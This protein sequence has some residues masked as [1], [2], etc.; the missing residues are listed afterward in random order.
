[1]KPAIIHRTTQAELTPYETLYTDSIDYLLGGALTLRNGRIDKYQFDEGYC[2]AERYTSTKDDFTFC[3]YDKDHLGNVR[4]VTELDGTSKGS[5][6]QRNNYYPFGAE[7]CDNLAK[8]YVQRQ[9][10]NGKEFDNMHGLNTYDYG[11]RQYNPVTAR[12]DRVDP[13]AHEYYGV[14][15]YVYCMNNPVKFVDPDGRN[16]IVFIKL[17][18]L[19]MEILSKDH[20]LKTVGYAINHPFNA[21]KT[22]SATWAGSISNIASNFEINIASG[23]GLT[24]RHPGDQGNAIRHTLW[25]SIL[26]TKFGEAQAERIGSIHEDGNAR[27]YSNNIYL[28]LEDADAC[29]DS[30][31]NNI[32]RSIG[33]ANSNADNKT[34]AKKVLQAFH[35]KGLY[36][37]S[38]L[39]GKYIVKLER[40]SDKQYQKALQ[41]IDKK[42]NNGLNK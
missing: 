8:S 9:K 20:N 16:P 21:Y 42:N 30:K 3:Y 13:L 39:N 22:G 26:T 23:A 31:N 33:K 4:Q 36:V 12:W 10:Y 28:K 17:S 24:Y 15:P 41:I 35:D 14:S 1:M 32:G 29:A 7:F 11:A 27:S 2:Q 34:L 19:I 5:V 18:G 25:Q 40:I 38:S 37:V 6:I